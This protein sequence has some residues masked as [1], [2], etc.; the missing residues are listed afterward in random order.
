MIIKEV[1]YSYIDRKYKLGPYVEFISELEVPSADYDCI[2][3]V[4]QKAHPECEQIRLLR[5]SRK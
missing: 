4:I 3:N 5:Y 2:V 1:K